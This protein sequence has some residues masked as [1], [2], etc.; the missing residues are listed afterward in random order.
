MRQK[1][2]L[3]VQKKR[4]RVSGC[5]RLKYFFKG[6][7]VFPASGFGKKTTCLELVRWGAGSSKTNVMCCS[8][9]NSTGIGPCDDHI[10]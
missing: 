3:G 2:T 10:R 9:S 8:R 5:A 1:A 4:A 6:Q 7:I